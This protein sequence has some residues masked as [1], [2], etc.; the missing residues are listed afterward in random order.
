M[1]ESE[2]RS[3][4]PVRDDEGDLVPATW[5]GARGET[6]VHRS[7]GDVHAPLPYGGARGRWDDDA[8]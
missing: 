1:R 3:M 8:I 7:S 6:K 5:R 4:L 2:R